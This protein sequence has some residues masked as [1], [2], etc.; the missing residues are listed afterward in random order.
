MKRCSVREAEG[1]AE[2]GGKKPRSAAQ[3][4]SRRGEEGL[5]VH[6][7]AGVFLTEE[8]AHTVKN[9]G[10][11]TAGG[12]G[13]C[14]WGRMEERREGETVTVVPTSHLKRLLAALLVT[15]M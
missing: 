12:G 13:G 5:L 1:E 7:C 3:S 2:R 15:G 14:L 10:L 11:L 6:D 4:R 8:T 9:K